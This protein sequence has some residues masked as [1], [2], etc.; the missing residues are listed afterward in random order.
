M[1]D[2]NLE[3]KAKKNERIGIGVA[4]RLALKRGPAIDIYELEPMLAV[5]ETCTG[6]LAHEL[7][8]QG[9]LLVRHNKGLKCKAC[10]VYRADRQFNFRNRTPCVPRPCA[11]TEQRV[12]RRFDQ[13]VRSGIGNTFSPSW[14]L[15]S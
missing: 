9:H 11:E 8:Q 13:H 6:K 12:H 10:N 7:A 15:Q 4:K 14:R 3:R 5:E 1:S 2:L